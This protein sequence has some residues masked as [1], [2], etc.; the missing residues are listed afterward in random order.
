M[1]TIINTERAPQAIGPY[2]QAVKAGQLLFVSGQIPINAQSGELVQD[3][4]QA[5]TKQVL[6]NLQA[7][8]EAAGAQMKDIIKTTIFL[9]D[10]NNFALVNET[11][12]GYFQSEPPARACV[13]VSRLPKD[14]NVEIEAVVFLG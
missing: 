2:S 6:E 3:G 10:M 12:G 7:I 14:V 13:E 5:E 11:Y 9:K 1:R 8:V 4:I